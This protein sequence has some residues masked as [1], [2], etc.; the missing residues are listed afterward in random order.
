MHPGARGKKLIA[1]A[2]AWA[3]G[4]APGQGPVADAAEVADDLEFFGA[5][6]EL[7]AQWRGLKTRSEVE[8]HWDNVAAFLLFDR[9]GSQWRVTGISGM[10]G[11]MMMRTGIDYGAVEM[12]AR[13]TNI[14][15]DT[16]TFGKLRVLESAALAA[17]DK[18]R[19]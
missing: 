4:R 18:Q 17:W 19:S 14:H 7:V 6:P 16:E 1:A 8:V 10:G 13:V 15:L 9:L 3:T 5:A 12:V 11:A 2:Q